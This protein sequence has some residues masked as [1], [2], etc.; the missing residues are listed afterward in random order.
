MHYFNNQN[1]TTCS[2]DAFDCYKSLAKNDFG[3]REPCTGLYAGIM[4]LS[5]VAIFRAD[6][7]WTGDED[8]ANDPKLLS[9]KDN[10]L[11]IK[12]GKLRN[13]AFNSNATKGGEIKKIDENYSPHVF[14]K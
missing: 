12:E 14:Q 7:R 4:P 5:G 13:I 6:V 1:F 3:C 2:P 9:L 10:Y 8:L 11:K